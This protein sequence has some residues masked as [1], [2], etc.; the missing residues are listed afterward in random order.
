M[1]K[2]DVEKAI[3]YS[4][5]FKSNSNQLLSVIAYF[6]NEMLT[7]SIVDEPEKVDTYPLKEFTK[8]K[9]NLHPRDIIMPPK[10]TARCSDPDPI[11]EVWGQ[12]R[13]SIPE[14]THTIAIHR[15]ATDM[16]QAIE[17]YAEGKGKK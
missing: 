7:Q 15:F 11:I 8:I 17:K 1:K 6:V 16:W 3:E 4:K 2:F 12:I 14:C 9:L 5:R 13:K 10:E